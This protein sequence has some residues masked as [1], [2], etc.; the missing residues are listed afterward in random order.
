[1]SDQVK[2]ETI[3]IAGASGFIGS[4]L[5][6]RLKS[7]YKIIGLSRTR[8]TTQGNVTWRSCDLFSVKETEQ[9]LR[10]ADTAVY[11]VHSMMPSASLTQGGFDDLDLLIADNFARAAKSSGIRRIIYLSGLIPDEVL[12]RHL[13][14]RLEV[15]QVLGEH[16]V[17]CITLRAGLV[18]G[19]QGSSFT[20]MR[21]LVERL[22]VMIC[23]GWTSTRTQPVALSDVTDVIAAVIS[24]RTLPA[25]NYDLGGSDVMTY[26]EM[27]QETA[28]QLGKKRWFF[29]IFLFSPKLSRLWV[30]L[31][32]GSPK[33][34]IGPLVE[35]LKHTMVARDTQIM[36]RYGITGMSF[37][38]ALAVALSASDKIQAASRAPK[39]LKVLGESSLTPINTVCSVQRLPLPPGCDADWVAKTY[40]NWL[41]SFLYPFIRVSRDDT[42]SL[43]FILGFGPFQVSML[44]LQYAPERSSPHRQLFY[45]QGGALLSSK[46]IPKGRFEFREVLSGRFVMTAI[47]DFVPALPWR[48]YR[49]T[50][51][52]LHLFV[53]LSFKVHLM[54]LIKSKAY[55]VSA[56]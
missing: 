49:V 55:R 19:P 24:D 15:E 1:M 38:S 23:P 29:P 45:I 20:I 8:N 34:L 7:H 28:R 53:M 40:A 10:G 54:K 56:H 3:A 50:Q 16:Q 33:E 17:P 44:R 37:R 9:G 48:L 6:E 47:F 14:S 46:S 11:L 52:P 18:V 39:L 26:I 42:G 2:Q 35:S 12:S 21:K 22:P 32:T 4:A 51:A 5:I 13:K 25:G 43:T 31:V 36:A 41:I 27:M 30:K